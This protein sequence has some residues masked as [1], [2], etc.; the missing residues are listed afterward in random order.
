MY[1]QIIIKYLI[2][3]LISL[4]GIP[5]LYYKLNSQDNYSFKK[6]LSEKDFTFLEIIFCIICLT[7]IFIFS[8]IQLIIPGVLCI[9]FIFFFGDKIENKGIKIIFGKNYLYSFILIFLLY[10]LMLFSIN[11]YSVIERLNNLNKT[12]F[13][14][15][16][17]T[18]LIVLGY[19]FKVKFKDF[20][21]NIRFRDII[22]SFA[23]FSLIKVLYLYFSDI[24]VLKNLS[25]DYFILNFIQQ[26]YYPSIIEEVLFRGFLFSA[27]LTFNIRSDTANIIQALIFGF[28]H[29]LGYKD[30]NYLSLF[31]PFVQIFIGYL[32]G[33]MY[34]KN[35]SL[36]S[37][38]LLHA[39]I[40]TL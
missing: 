26:L 24:D 36:S 12:R 7:F 10:S 14:Q 38:I 4:L 20:N 6:W 27:L 23:I 35:K 1:T 15:F 5:Y 31:A 28:S 3:I 18:V 22:F 8:T 29:L 37:C 32:F 17:I 19:I 33:K 30:I 2:I 34:L 21:W 13:V 11:Y 9:Y 39:L 25:F 40:D 16:C